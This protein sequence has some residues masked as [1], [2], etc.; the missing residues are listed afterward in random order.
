MVASVGLAEEAW[1]R[2]LRAAQESLERGDLGAAERNLN[3]AI[4]GIRRVGPE[5][6]DVFSELQVLGAVQAQ[7]G[8]LEKGSR[9]V[10]RALELAEIAY[11]ANDPTLEPFWSMLGT[12]ELQRGEY[13]RAAEMLDRSYRV[14]M[15]NVSTENQAFREVLRNYAEALR[16]SGRERDLLLLQSHY[17]HEVDLG[18]LDL[19]PP[20]PDPPPAPPPPPVQREPTPPAPSRPAPKADSKPSSRRDEMRRRL[21]SGGTELPPLGDLPP[22]QPSNDVRRIRR[23]LMILQTLDYQLRTGLPALKDHESW[24]RR[25]LRKYRGRRR[26]KPE[27]TAGVFHKAVSRGGQLALLL[28]PVAAIRKMWPALT[29]EQEQA[30]ARSIRARID[31]YDQTF[32]ETSRSLKLLMQRLLPAD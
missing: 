29:S 1:Q 15:G 27:L 2:S 28:Q 14:L 19:P 5:H 23:N 3:R 6:R 9:L 8:R 22:V 13:P 20:R 11:G 21:T 16:R 10:G 32:V 17:G 18:P 4:R 31:E 24:I 12:L 25:Q 7:E 26:Y 30:A